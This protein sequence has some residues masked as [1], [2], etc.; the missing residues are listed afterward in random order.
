[1]GSHRS[2]NAETVELLSSSSDS[3]VSVDKNTV[4]LRPK[5]RSQRNQLIHKNDGQAL[6]SVDIVRPIKRRREAKKEIQYA[7]DEEEDEEE[8]EEEEED[9]DATENYVDHIE[10]TVS[11]E[12]HTIPEK[13][14]TRRRSQRKRKSV[15]LMTEYSDDDFIM[16]SDEEVEKSKSAPRV[17]KR[18]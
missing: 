12:E 5:L 16:S 13:D 10:G 11:E 8:E 15:P 2:N 1:M 7:Y 4:S 17:K 3:D 9:E 14:T 18:W 6:S